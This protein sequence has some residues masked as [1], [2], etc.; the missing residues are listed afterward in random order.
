MKSIATSSRSL[1][2][3]GSS[4]SRNDD[5]T[6]QKHRKVNTGLIP[7]IGRLV[8]LLPTQP[9]QQSDGNGKLITSRLPSEI[10]TSHRSSNNN[11]NNRTAATTD[12]GSQVLVLDAGVK[13]CARKYNEAKAHAEKLEEEL[14]RK[15]DE[16]KDLHRER[17]A[18]DGMLSGN[19]GEAHRIEELS[20]EIEAINEASEQQLHY[21]LQLNHVEDR[22]K[23]KSLIMDGEIRTLSDSVDASERELTKAERVLGEVQS[24]HA[25]AMRDLE[26]TVREVE[27]ERQQR[28]MAYSKLQSEASN[29]EQMKA[30]R[31]ECQG[32]RVAA[33]EEPFGGS[34]SHDKEKKSRAVKERRAEVAQLRAELQTKVATSNDLEDSFKNIKEAIG[35][36]N[37]TEMLEKFTTLQEQ[38]DRLLLEKKDAEERLNT[39]RASLEKAKGKFSIAKA[40][41]VGETEINRDVINHLNEWIAHEKAECKVVS[42]L[43]ERMESVLVGLRQGVIGLYQRLLPFYATFFEGEAP[44]LNE[45]DTTSAI[46]AAHNTIELLEVSE[47]I[48]EKMLDEV[49]GVECISNTVSLLNY[50]TVRNP[51]KEEG[52]LESFDD[53]LE[54]PNLGENNCRILAKENSPRVLHAKTIKTDNDDSLNEA[55]MGNDGNINVCDAGNRIVP[56]RHFLKQECLK[57][58]N[59]CLA[60]AQE[61]NRTKRKAGES[62]DTKASTYNVPGRPTSA[63]SGS[64]ETTSKQ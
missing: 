34:N 63:I 47:Q 51:N 55:N 58:H 11:S 7:G 30:W 54:N 1:N 25:K 52:R 10:A 62:T 39:V 9:E 3:V 42:S 21:R 49:G 53:T 23:K 36:N 56:S 29:A 31:M 59:E 45:R 38:R 2:N 8:S 46:Q 20:R 32:S 41:G 50:H 22:S 6:I 35:A 28:S 24:S 44:Q 64:D 43:N 27:L 12:V 26:K 57:Y 61:Q 19:K 17:V 18:L 60:T 4:C 13:L 40:S 33:I 14:S 16:L 15:L 48:L 37:L 5:T